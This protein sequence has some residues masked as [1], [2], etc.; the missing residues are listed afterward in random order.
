LGINVDKVRQAFN[1]GN[2]AEIGVS[3]VFDE[4]IQKGELLSTTINKSGSVL[5]DTTNK[6]NNLTSIMQSKQNSFETLFNVNNAIK[7]AATVGQIGSIMTSITNLGNIIKNEDLSASEK[8][9]KVLTNIGFLLPMIINTSKNISSL[10]GITNALTQRRL[11]L[12]QKI[13]KEKERQALLDKKAEIAEKA[14]V[15]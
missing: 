3:K 7:F 8:L 4:A 13:S 1:S 10:L 6:I 12:E 11:F 2:W 5:E 9:A 14:K 15:L